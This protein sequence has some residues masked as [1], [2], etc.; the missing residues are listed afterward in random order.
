MYRRGKC[1]GV[2][3]LAGVLACASTPVVF[4]QP[5]SSYVDAWLQWDDAG[6]AQVHLILSLPERELLAAGEPSAPERMTVTASLLDADGR[7]FAGEAWASDLTTQP[8]AEGDFWHEYSLPLPQAGRSELVVGIVLRGRIILSGWRRSF[9]V[10]E[11]PAQSPQITEPVWLE[12]AAAERPSLSRAYVE[13]DEPRVRSALWLPASINTTGESVDVHWQILSGSAVVGSGHLQVAGAPGNTP[14]ELQLPQ[15][16]SGI[17]GLQLQAL[18]GEAEVRGGG[19]WQ[20]V[21]GTLAWGDSLPAPQMLEVI[22]PAAAVQHLQSAPAAQQLEIWQDYL[23]T[24]QPGDPKNALLLLQQ[25]WQEASAR[26]TQGAQAGWQTD[27]GRVYIR[28]GA[29]D[30]LDRLDDPSNAQRLERWRYR[31]ENHVFLF[32]DARGNGEYVLERTNDPNYP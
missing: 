11:L 7:R 5:S 8:L 2:F 27:R 29:P 22:L 32:R 30:E 6:Q 14:F 17:Y 1:I 19:A 23:Q 26:F 13:S 12:A 9:A 18:V 25:R 15:L 21:P 16:P 3:V 10:A 28:R 4:R 24:L 20:V 31:R